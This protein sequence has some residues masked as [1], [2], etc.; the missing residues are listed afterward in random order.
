MYFLPKQIKVKD[1]IREG[2]MKTQDICFK[3]LLFFNM[4]HFLA[5]FCTLFLQVML[6]VLGLSCCC[7]L[8]NTTSFYPV[9]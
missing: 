7:S 2:N 3:P 9:A 6:D 4:K 8:F 5:F 1:S